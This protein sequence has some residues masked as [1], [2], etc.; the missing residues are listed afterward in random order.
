[1]I[2]RQNMLR[3]FLLNSSLLVVSLHGNPHDYK[4]WQEPTA[5]GHIYQN[6]MTLPLHKKILIFSYGSL[7][8]QKENKK[9]GDVLK[10]TSFAKTE[11]QVPVSFTFLAGCS[12]CCQIMPNNYKKF[13]NCRATVTIDSNSD[14]FKNIWA[15]RSKFH[16]LQNARNNLAAREGA[17][18]LGI[19]K[20]YE[21][22]HIFYIRKLSYQYPK[23]S[24][25]TFIK[26]FQDWVT[27]KPYKAHQ[28]LPHMVLSDMVNYA[29]KKNAD[30][31]IWAALP[32]NIDAESL[33]ILLEHNKNF[34]KNS[35]N[36]IKK[37][38]PGNKYTDFEQKILNLL[39]VP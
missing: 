16:S 11:I 24:Y 27:L 6:E 29:L 23:K 4:P 31:A 7:V 37:L 30:A 20:G 35:Y 38:T 14:E 21:V 17:P 15:A 36:Y 33:D 25:E 2:I 3:N 8:S 34:V 9:T 28:K 26:S 32:S 19:H 39:V 10:A 22:K 18:F 5:R 1:M 13:P 12:P